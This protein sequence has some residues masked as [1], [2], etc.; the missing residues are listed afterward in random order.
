MY[1]LNDGQKCDMGFNIASAVDILCK[2]A[3]GSEG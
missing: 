3:I 1:G 2:E